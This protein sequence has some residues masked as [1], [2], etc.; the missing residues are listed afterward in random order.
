MTKTIVLI[1]GAWLN[2]RSWEAFKARYE[3]KGFKVVA[4]DWPHDDRSPRLASSVRLS[5]QHTAWLS[6]SPRCGSPTSSAASSRARCSL[7]ACPARPILPF[8]M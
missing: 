2:S 5:G 4:P 3:A 6:A 8:L 1:H 7:A